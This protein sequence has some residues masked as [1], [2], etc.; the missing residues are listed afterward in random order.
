MFGLY[1]ILD[2]VLVLEK[3]DHVLYLTKQ[4]SSG[5]AENKISNY[6]AQ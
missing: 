4:Q 2:I 3:H 6:N 5:E 1:C